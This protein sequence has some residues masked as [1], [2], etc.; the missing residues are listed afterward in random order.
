MLRVRSVTC[1][2][3]LGGGRPDPR[4]GRGWSELHEGKGAFARA[5]GCGDRGRVSGGASFCIGDTSCLFATSVCFAWQFERTSHGATELNCAL[6]DV[7]RALT[8]L[9]DAQAG[10]ARGKRTQGN[11]LGSCVGPLPSG[12]AIYLA[13]PPTWP[14]RLSGP[15]GTLLLCSAETSRPQ[16]QSTISTSCRHQLQLNSRRMSYD[17][18]T[19]SKW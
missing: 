18:H 3:G 12:P 6:C 2:V 15:A 14:S 9:C 19:T 1:V 4:A 16:Y 10:A 8:L 13:Q 11:S 17:E 5:A 7:K